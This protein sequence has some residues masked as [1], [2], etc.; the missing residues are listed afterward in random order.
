LREIRRDSYVVPGPG[1]LGV[2]F[3]GLIVYVDYSILTY[4]CFHLT[5]VYCDSN[6]LPWKL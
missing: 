3:D 5:K 4:L 1:L 6:I 2:I